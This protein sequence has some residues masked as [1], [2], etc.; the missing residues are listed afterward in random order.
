[1]AEVDNTPQDFFLCPDVRNIGRPEWLQS[2]TLWDEGLITQCP[3]DDKGAVRFLSILFQNNGF[4]LDK[5]TAAIVF[6][7][8]ELHRK[9]FFKVDGFPGM[10]LSKLVEFEG[11]TFAP[12]AAKLRKILFD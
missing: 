6:R 1:M 12:S 2:D 5:E 4:S 11:T 8:V 3:S 7:V 9:M 10:F